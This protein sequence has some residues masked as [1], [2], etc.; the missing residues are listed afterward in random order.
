MHLLT[1]KEAYLLGVDHDV[2]LKRMPEGAGDCTKL[3]SVEL[4]HYVAGVYVEKP[5][6]KKKKA[7][8]T[9]DDGQVLPPKKRAKKRPAP[10]SYFTD[11]EWAKK[12]AKVRVIVERYI[13]LKGD[14]E[15]VVVCMKHSKPPYVSLGMEKC[16][17]CS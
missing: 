15:R 5:E 2:A 8:P 14:P 9:D 1:K 16:G 10:V 12:L 17:I 13:A 7:K 4:G 6:P 11:E 3:G